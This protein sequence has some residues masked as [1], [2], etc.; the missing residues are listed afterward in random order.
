M[1]EQERTFLAKDPKE[2]L[3]SCFYHEQRIKEK[4]ELIQHYRELSESITQEIK[5]VTTFGLTPSCKIEKCAIEIVC[6]EEDI[7]KE[8]EAL[9]YD[10]RIVQEAIDLLTD[11]NMKLLLEARY[12]R[13]AKWEEIMELLDISYRWTLRLHGIALQKISE[14]AALV[15]L[16]M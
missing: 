12:L 14:Q 5:E 7:L 16:E 11:G 9:K 4:Q 13:H 3:K 2:F 6:I 10:R 1:T 8:V 15:T